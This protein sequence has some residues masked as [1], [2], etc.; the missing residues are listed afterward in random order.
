MMKVRV[1]AQV[2]SIVSFFEA[3]GNIFITLMLY[4]TI[5][6][7]FGTVLIQSTLYLIILP[8]FSLMNT[9][10]NKDRIIGRGWMGVIKNLWVGKGLNPTQTEDIISNPNN[11]KVQKSLKRP[12]TYQANV[13][14]ANTSTTS[15]A[16]D[17]IRNVKINA[18][19]QF[20]SD[21]AQ[22]TS[23]RLQL[24]IKHHSTTP[25]PVENRLETPNL[26]SVSSIDT[27]VSKMILNTHE[28]KEYM[29]SFKK[30]VE[31]VC[32]SD[33]LQKCPEVQFEDGSLPNS[34]PD[35]SY[36]Q[37]NDKCKVKRSN[38]TFAVSNKM[39]RSKMILDVTELSIDGSNNHEQKNS[40]KAFR[41]NI[42]KEIKSCATDDPKR[43]LLIEELIDKE[44]RYVS[45]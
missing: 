38:Q 25:D 24:H 13:N 31:H 26:N 7:N 32:T 41:D 33:Q 17:P 35:I 37:R 1:N 22:S 29:R 8:Y 10:Y 42:L 16:L 40:R 14:Q 30:L 28:E 39:F 15:S 11:V 21:R 19:E 18:S 6:R 3:S 27:I 43:H 44:E 34:V 2:K 5:R 36:R 9:S 20:F 45:Y 4:F 12:S 23:N